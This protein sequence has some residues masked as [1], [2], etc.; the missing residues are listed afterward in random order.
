MLFG[1]L[2][3]QHVPGSVPLLL[4]VILAMEFAQKNGATTIGVTGDYGGKGSG[5]ISNFSD[6]LVFFETKSM[7]RIED[8]QLIF[9]H[10]VKESL[11]LSLND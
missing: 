2:Q 1:L 7:E 11:K 10:M 4:A 3:H 9:N 5:K 6:I 8:L